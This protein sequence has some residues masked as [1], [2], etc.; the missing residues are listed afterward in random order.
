MIKS[1]RSEQGQRVTWSVFTAIVVSL[2]LFSISAHAGDAGSEP[3]EPMKAPFPMPELTR[4][5]FPNHVVNIRDHGA[6]EG[7]T[8]KNTA[9]FE[10]AIEVCCKQGGGRVVVPA[11][12]WLTGPI[13]LKSNIELHFEKGAQLLFS[14]RF[15]D[16]LPPVLVRSGGIEAY[17]Y[18]PLIYARDC[19]NIAV[20]GEGRLDGNGKAWWDWKKKETKQLFNMGAAGVPVE[21]RLFGTEE[22]AIRPSFVSFISCKNVLLE[23]FTIVSGPAW[24]IHPVYC[25]NVIIRRI[26]VDTHGPNND[27]MDPDSCRNLL[28][29]HCNFTTGDD[30]LV[31]K[32][33]YNEDGWRVGR[34]TENVVMRYCT[35][36]EGHGG[37][38]IG[39]EMS[40]GVRNVYMHDCEFEGTDRAVRIKSRIDRGGV[41]ENVW[42]ENVKAMAVGR[43]VVVLNMD[44]SSDHNTALTKVPPVFRNMHFKNV[45]GHGARVAILMTGLAESPIENIEFES[46]T[47]ASKDGIEASDVKG[48]SFKNVK[49]TP[50][51][52]AVFDLTNASKITISNA[53]AAMGSKVF[54]KLQG[55]DSSGVSI[56]SSDLS[57]V[58]QPV[59]LAD[60]VSA[61]SVT[62]K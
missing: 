12:K 17:N 48:L 16:Y 59:E 14:D 23:G 26:N 61:A 35:A 43:E 47:I 15:E 44:Y 27:G 1:S 45:T 8:E 20:T 21:K 37:L 34:P 32:S 51:H 36:K 4:P 7:G 57:G 30:C 46:I 3:I 55:K 31:L 56:E 38:A 53:A 60:G 18:S 33:G 29:E 9:A 25:E 22:A 49:I 58:K 52:G 5:V 28:V 54:L 50:S 2:G 24:T 62:L 19:E 41:V 42:V 10:E 40:G 13:H 11:G 6:V 39:S